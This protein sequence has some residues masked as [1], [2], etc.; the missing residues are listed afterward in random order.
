MSER[1]TN[2]S[3][4]NILSIMGR[5]YKAAFTECPVRMLIYSLVL[6]ANGVIQIVITYE[7]K[8]FFDNVSLGARERAVSPAIIFSFLFLMAAILMSHILKVIV[9]FLGE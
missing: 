1:R 3:G 7:T 6:L 8:L 4:Y 2:Q 9:L 5:L